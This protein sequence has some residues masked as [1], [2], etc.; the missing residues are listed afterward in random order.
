M[1]GREDKML[2]QLRETA[3]LGGPAAGLANELLVL[4]DQFTSG[5]LTREEFEFLVSEIA[6]IRAQQE[7]AS[8]EM[9]CRFIIESAKNILSMVA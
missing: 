7:L 8:D 5:Q 9:A 6:N 1:H 2:E 4:Q 3:G